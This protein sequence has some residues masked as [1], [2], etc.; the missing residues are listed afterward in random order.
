MLAFDAQNTPQ[1]ESRN[2][3]VGAWWKWEG[4]RGERT[5]RHTKP[6][7]RNTDR[8]AAFSSR[9]NDQK[10]MPLDGSFTRERD[11]EAETDKDLSR[12]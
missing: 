11:C 4:W 3:S 12:Y 10:I 9:A 8:D 6:V 7:R 5:H 2:R 1:T